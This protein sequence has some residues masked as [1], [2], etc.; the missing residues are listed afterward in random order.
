MWTP[1]EDAAIAQLVLTHGTRNWSVIAEGVPSR[2]G[3]QCRERWHNHLDPI[4]NKNEWSAEEDRILLDSHKVMGNKWAE[5]AKVLP[6]RTDNQ[7]KNRY[8]SALRRELRKLNRLA[9]K[10]RGAVAT[11]MN[12]ATAAAMSAAGN[13]EGLDDGG[14]ADGADVSENSPPTAGKG[15]GCKRPRAGQPSSEELT[16]CAL[17]ESTDEVLEDPITTV[18]RILLTAPSVLI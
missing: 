4:I 7:I 2:S 1:E 17:A 12:A 11:A 9:N 18:P 16:A 8:N 5:I 15:R 6:G 14:G 3:K 10:Q 13:N